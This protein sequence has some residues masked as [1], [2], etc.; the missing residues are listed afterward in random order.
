VR[1]RSANR[2][3]SYNTW[4]VNTTG[5]I[6]ENNANNA[7]R[8]APVCLYCRTKR[9]LCKGGAPKYI[10]QRAEIPARVGE[11]YYGDASNFFIRIWE[12]YTSWKLIIITKVLLSWRVL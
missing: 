5:N 8:F 6:N 7:N 10:I 12:L 1:L 4:N 9:L 11:Q 3:N 2:N